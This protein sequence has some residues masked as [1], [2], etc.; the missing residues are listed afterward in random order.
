[1][2]S[3][4]ALMTTR[5]YLPVSD[6]NLIL[7]G[8]TGPRQPAIGRRVATILQRTFVNID[9]Q[10]EERHEMSIEEIRTRFG[11][12]R[13]KTLESEVVQEALL[14]RSAV[15]R[16][17]GQTLLHSNHYERFNATGPVVCLVAS[18]DS[19]L[20]NLHLTLGARYHNPNERALVLGELQREWAVRSCPGI[21]EIDT[22]YKSEAEIADAVIALWQQLV[23]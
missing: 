16:V 9:M 23:L 7:T 21:Y 17:S 12:T 15:I 4:L 2:V 14:Y 10:I 22:T 13:L 19:V 11:E 6:R 18:L 8:Y 1:V 5:R 3:G 20:Q